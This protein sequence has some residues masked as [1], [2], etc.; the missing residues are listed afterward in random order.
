MH[1]NKSTQRQEKNTLDSVYFCSVGRAV[2]EIIKQKGANGPELLCFHL[3]ACCF[4]VVKGRFAAK[5]LSYE[6]NNL[7]QMHEHIDCLASQ[8]CR[9]VNGMQYTPPTVLTV[10]IKL[11]QLHII[12]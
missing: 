2:F 6:Y 11:A 1:W 4:L 12:K 8:L 3:L 7:E 5:D 10:C 9:S